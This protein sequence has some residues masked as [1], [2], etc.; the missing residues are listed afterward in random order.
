MKTLLLLRH[1]KSSWKD[2]DID[3]HERPLN[4]RGKK[5]AP[6]MGRLLLDE[7]MLPDLI[8]SSSAKRC[9]KTAEQVIQHSGYRGETRIIGELYEANLSKLRECLAKVEETVGRLLLIGHNPGLE[10][11]LEA[12]VGSYTP[13]STACLAQVEIAINRWSDCANEP[14]GNLVKVWQPRELED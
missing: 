12:L 1:A 8:L 9:R 4:K 7:S 11:L 13:L 5:D 6:R 3:D 10:E 14:R 2:S